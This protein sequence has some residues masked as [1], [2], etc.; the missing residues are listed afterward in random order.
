M[1]STRVS[2]RNFQIQS[3]KRFFSLFESQG[4]WNL[5]PQLFPHFQFR[6]IWFLVQNIKETKE[7]S[8]SKVIL[9]GCMGAFPSKDL[10]RDWRWSAWYFINFPKFDHQKLWMKIHQSKPILNEWH[11]I[12]I[13]HLEGTWNNKQ[14]LS[15]PYAASL[16][17]R[18]IIQTS[19]SFCETNLTGWYFQFPKVDVSNSFMS[20]VPSF[21]T[22]FCA[23]P[24]LVERMEFPVKHNAS[25]KN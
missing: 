16:E 19:P 23:S 5:W 4:V 25:M 22:T 21:L 18:C 9:Q 20:H 11:Q 13:R 1:K 10:S 2:F 7:T 14:F 3:F 6:H 12:Q 15:F 17:L 8:P 24:T